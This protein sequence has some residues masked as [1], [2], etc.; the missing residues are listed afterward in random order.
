MGVLVTVTPPEPEALVK[1]QEAKDHLRVLTN[2]EDEL[3]LG[4]IEAA[5]AWIDG[6]QGWVGQCFAPQE[7]ELR[8]NVF[9][10]IGRLLRLPPANNAVVDVAQPRAEGFATVDTGSLEVAED[11]MVRLKWTLEERE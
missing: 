11:Q 5:S 8:S 3:I 2:D 4:Y 7:L 6:Y 1:L 10:G 9:A